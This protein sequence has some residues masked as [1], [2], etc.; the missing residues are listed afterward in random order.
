MFSCIKLTHRDARYHRFLVKHD[1][2][3][4]YPFYQMD[5]LTFGD[6][7]FSFIAISTMHRRAED[8]GND[9]EKAIKAMKEH[10]YV[11]D[12]MNSFDNEEEAIEIS[13]QVKKN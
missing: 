4:E 9:R 12:Y 11:D 8:H 13:K 6:G 3:E 5:R 2:E 7:P 1:D 10:F